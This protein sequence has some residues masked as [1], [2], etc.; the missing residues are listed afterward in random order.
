MTDGNFKKGYLKYHNEFAFQIE[1]HGESCPTCGENDRNI[2]ECAKNVN[3]TKEIPVARFET[4]SMSTT[5][6][7][8]LGVQANIIPKSK[9]F[10][11]SIVNPKVPDGERERYF[12]FGRRVYD[13]R[14][15]A[16][17]VASPSLTKNH[18]QFTIKVPP[19]EYGFESRNFV[20]AS[21]AWATLLPQTHLFYWINNGVTAPGRVLSG[22]RVNP[23]A[24]PCDMWTITTMRPE[25][26]FI[27][28]E[29]YNGGKDRQYWIG[30]NGE[31]IRT[32][33]KDAASMF[34]GS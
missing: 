8:S 16:G 15:I 32:T 24:T 22:I 5:D 12:M 27:V 17:I 26:L 19:K 30:T 14:L 33:T 28:I 11:G 20:T 10:I 3:T 4:F 6:Q 18:G 29:G 25:C 2:A 13:G 1:W 23:N 34:K 21:V 9:T 7:N 31:G